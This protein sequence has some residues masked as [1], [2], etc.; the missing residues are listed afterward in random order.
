MQI[1]LVIPPNNFLTVIVGGS[2]RKLPP[3]VDSGEQLDKLFRFGMLYN[4]GYANQN[5]PHLEDLLRLFPYK[6]GSIY[7]MEQVDASILGATGRPMDD[8]YVLRHDYDEIVAYHYVSKM[9][10]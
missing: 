6:N 2:A 4:A 9:P 3:C 10:L 7:L 1:R 8:V 5:N